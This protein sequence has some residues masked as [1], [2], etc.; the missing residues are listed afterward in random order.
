MVHNLTYCFIP[1]DNDISDN[2]S[3]VVLI[4]KNGFASQEEA[5][6]QQKN[7]MHT[8]SLFLRKGFNLESESFGGCVVVPAELPLGVQ[9]RVASIYLFRSIIR[10]FPTQFFNTEPKSQF[11]SLRPHMVSLLFRSLTSEADEVVCAAE[12]ALQDALFGEQEQR[13]SSED[14][15]KPSHRLPKELIQACIR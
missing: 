10:K 2:M 13:D 4:D 7:R 14:S 6:T 12:S 15:P 9:L 5:T 8:S 3:S 11:E 1:A